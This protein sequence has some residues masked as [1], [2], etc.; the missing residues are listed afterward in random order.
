MCTLDLEDHLALDPAARVP[1]GNLVRYA[2]TAPLQPRA[3]RTILLGDEQD[4]KLLD[5]LG[6]VYAPST[7]IEP[8]AELLI[9][10]R[11]VKYDEQLHQY[12]QQ[13]GHLLLPA[14][15]GSAVGLGVTLG[16]SPSF[17]GSLQVPA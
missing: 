16:Q 4:R 10:G 17:A 14:R 7:R 2:A 6:V 5:L 13:G 11:Q 8:Q 15:S 3:Q 9:L 1:A 12:L